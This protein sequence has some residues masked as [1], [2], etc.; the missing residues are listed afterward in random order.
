[1]G[2]NARSTS[3][4]RLKNKNLFVFDRPVDNSDIFVSREVALTWV[5]DNLDNAISVPLTIDGAP[6]IGRTTFLK[7]IQKEAH[8]SNFVPIYV[9]LKQLP[10]DSFSE[11]LWV[12]GKSVVR[13]LSDNG[14]SAPPL[15][16]RMLVLR[17]R[18]S[19]QTTF[20][21]QL[22]KSYNGQRMV[23][24]LDHFEY[25]AKKITSSETKRSYRQYLYKLLEESQDIYALT[26][27]AGR[28]ATYDPMDIAPFHQSLNY[29][30]TQF[31][32]TQTYELINQNRILNI[33]QPVATY[34][35]LLTGGHPAD[36]QRL[37]HA[38]FERMQEYDLR[39]VTVADV[40]ATLRT[41]IKPA[42]FRRPVHQ[43]RVKISYPTIKGQA[44]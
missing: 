19:F 42:D 40:V 18:Q 6:G 21:R 34:I 28:L 37:C 22:I 20:W 12:F 13:E 43:Q 35:H 7:Q 11:F 36:I 33:L 27:L 16:K 29:R 9:N 1:M 4:E 26:S 38:I 15:E 17:P 39:V 8:L 23:L 3:P 10:L 2:N 14:L 5:F 30:I 32:R 41:G 25:L 44:Y 31:S 24:I